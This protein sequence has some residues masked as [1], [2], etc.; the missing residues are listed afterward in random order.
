MQNKNRP[1]GAKSSI[2]EFIIVALWMMPDLL[3][4]KFLV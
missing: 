1:T 4:E 2:N 3:H